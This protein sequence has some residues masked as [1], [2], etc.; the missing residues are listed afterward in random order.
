MVQNPV[1]LRGT[2]NQTLRTLIERWREDPGTTYQSWFL[3]E[4][5]LKN[6]RSIGRGIGQVIH[7]IES[8]F[9]GW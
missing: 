8:S 5:R 2:S 3:W 6:F 4:E 7:K 1:I 9:K